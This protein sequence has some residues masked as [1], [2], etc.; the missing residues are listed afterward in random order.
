MTQIEAIIGGLCTGMLLCNEI[1]QSNNS[2]TKIT[3]KLYKKRNC[4][5][6]TA[7]VVYVACM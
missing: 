1:A 5:T 4:T 2:L 3:R 6:S 7:M